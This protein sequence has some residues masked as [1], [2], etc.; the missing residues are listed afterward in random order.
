MSLRG[1]HARAASPLFL[2][3][4]GTLV[5]RSRQERKAKSR[6]KNMGIIREE[7]SHFRVPR[8]RTHLR[9]CPLA[10]CP[11]PCILRLPLRARLAVA[12]KAARTAADSRNWALG[13]PP[14]SRSVSHTGDSSSLID[15]A[16]FSSS[17]CSFIPILHSLSRSAKSSN[18]ENFQIR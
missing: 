12:T 2:F 3:S 10:H 13:E 14:I 9:Y 1:A 16:P 17:H 15:I 7:I 18:T 8:P 4:D 5:E 11:S 6:K